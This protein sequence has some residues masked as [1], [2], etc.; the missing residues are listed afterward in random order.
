M[1]V[2]DLIRKLRGFG[3][4]SLTPEERDFLLKEY[5]KANPLTFQ[6]KHVASIWHLLSEEE[7][8]VAREKW[9]IFF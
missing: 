9:G 1:N 7:K 4:G 6:G 3:S 5:Q 2:Q 8:E